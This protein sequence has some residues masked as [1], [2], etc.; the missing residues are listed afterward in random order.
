MSYVKINTSNLP[1][2]FTC[3]FKDLQG[4]NFNTMKSDTKQHMQE[5]KLVNIKFLPEHCFFIPVVIM[6]VGKSRRKLVQ[7][8]LKPDILSFKGRVL[9]FHKRSPE[10][11][12]R[13]KMSSDAH[14]EKAEVNLFY[15]S[16]TFT[17]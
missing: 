12:P 1:C 8:C 15:F 4:V 2:I 16:R 17:F 11:Y 3:L 6:K 7:S 14:C 9:M 10:L 5:E 13:A